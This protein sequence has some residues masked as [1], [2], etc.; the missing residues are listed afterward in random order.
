MFCR[1]HVTQFSNSINNAELNL[2][3]SR[4]FILHTFPFILLHY[5]FF[6]KI[7]SLVLLSQHFVLE[8]TLRTLLVLT[9]IKIKFSTEN[10]F[11]YFLCNVKSYTS[12]VAEIYENIELDIWYLFSNNVSSF[13]YNNLE[14]I[15]I[16]RFK[17]VFSIGNV[18]KNTFSY[19]AIYLIKRF[20]VRYET[21][22]FNFSLLSTH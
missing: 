1:Q 22:I 4:Y 21:D 2:W 3:L 19:S 17:M 8:S 18:N 13:K 16:A 7:D 14:M 9:L 6:Q 12:N 5:T 20:L 10:Y 11:N 15:F